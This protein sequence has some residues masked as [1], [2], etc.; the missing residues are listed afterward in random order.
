MAGLHSRAVSPGSH[1]TD[2]PSLLLWTWNSSKLG[3]CRVLL[4]QHTLAN[5]LVK[6]MDPKKPAENVSE[7][8]WAHRDGDGFGEGTCHDFFL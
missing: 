2:R 4:P 5:G 6:D 1:S 7:Q 8:P 3:D